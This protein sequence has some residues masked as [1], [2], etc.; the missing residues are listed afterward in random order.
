MLTGSQVILSAIV[1]FILF[2]TYHAYKKD[3]ISTSFALLWVW[4]WMLVL[5]FI[6]WQ[7]LL[8]RIANFIGIGRGV[9]LATYISIILIF[10]LIYK[11]FTKLEDINHKLTK[12][13]RQKALG[14]VLKK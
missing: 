9:D 14:E 8:T 1:L 7:S 6:N 13:I 5:L 11:I 3:K 4:F 2:K 12:I 10:Y